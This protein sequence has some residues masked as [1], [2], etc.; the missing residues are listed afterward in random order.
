LKVLGFYTKKLFAPWPLNFAIVNISDYYVIIGVLLI[1]GFVFILYK[2]SIISAL[3]LISVCILLPALLAAFG[4]MTWTPLAERYLY[5]PSAT[6]CIAISLL[7]CNYLK[8]AKD[9]GRTI[10]L[11]FVPVVFGSCVYTTVNRNITWQSN[12]TL[13]QDTI[14]NSTHFLLAKIAIAVALAMSER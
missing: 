6:F 3:F 7:L 2:R 9:T 8:Q 5:I 10:H 4:R 1:I 11:F 14:R 12:T 13:F